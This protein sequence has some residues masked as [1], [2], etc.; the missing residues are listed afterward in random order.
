MPEYARIIPG[1]TWLCLSVPKS[2]GMAFVLHLPIV[3][4]CIKEL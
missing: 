2:V 1:F 3:I 4:P